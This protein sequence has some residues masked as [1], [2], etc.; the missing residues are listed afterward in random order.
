[1]QMEAFHWKKNQ[2]LAEDY[3][4]DSGTANHLFHFH[5]KRT[6]DWLTRAAWVTEQSSA[7]RAD[8]HQLAAVLTSYNER[9]G[10]TQQALQKIQDL[11]KSESLVVVGGQQAGLF[12]GP[13]LVLYKAITIIQLA[14]EWSGKLSR[15][16]VPVFWIAGEDHD[17]DEVNHIY[18][19][20]SAQTVEKIKVEHPTGQR[21]SISRLPLKEHVW[22]A[23]L[24]ALEDSLIDTE[25]K[26]ELLA[27]LKNAA[28]PSS[29][30]SDA[31]ARWMAW[32]FGE[33]G[34]VLLDADD[35]PLRGVESAMFEQLIARNEAL[36]DALMQG[37]KRVRE[38]GYEPQADITENGANLFVFEKGG[39]LLLQREDGLFTDKKKSVSYS[40][41]QLLD[42]SVTHPQ[43]LSNNVMTRPLMQEYLFPVLATVLGP[44]EIAYWGLTAS[45]FEMFG[46]KLPIVAPRLEFTLIEGTVHKHMVRY[47]LS[48][49]DVLNRFEEKKQSWLSKQDTMRLGERFEVVKEEF[50]ASYGP[51]VDSLAAINAGVK[52]LGESNLAKILNQIEYLEQKAADGHKAQFESTLR[53]LDRIQ[54]TIRPLAKP[55]ERVYNGCA[56]MNRYGN[57]WLKQLV[58]TPIPVDGQHRIYYL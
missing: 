3:I 25:F 26:A 47:D 34:L 20:T 10:N 30:L 48:F 29:T 38:C 27:K 22:I 42:I 13:L 2:A 37:R 5:Y 4:Q 33:Y 17:F 24:Q 50:K 1:M 21:T 54:L 52:L 7:L 32:L 44:G 46:M 8:R 9:I 35:P 40:R 36:S 39:R 28:L 19:L 49:D 12:G 11:S 57:G 43:R 51:L 55:Q 56:Y 16:I 6:E 58:E 41:E 15:P 53:H 45:A 23:A 31:F 18:S 14:R